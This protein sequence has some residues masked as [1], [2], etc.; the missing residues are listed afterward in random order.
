MSRRPGKNLDVTVRTELREDF[1]K[2]PEFDPEQTFVLQ[3]VD[4]LP[5]ACTRHGEQAV[6]QPEKDF[7]FRPRRTRRDPDR[8]RWVQRTATYE[9]G[10]LLR[11]IYRLSTFRWQDNSPP[12]TILE[13]AWPVCAK[14]QR[15]RRILQ[16]IGHVI[17]LAGV[18]LILIVLAATQTTSSDH[19]PVPLV[20]AVFPGWLPFGLLAAVLI[21][22]RSTTYVLFRPIT[23]LGS[24]QIVAHPDFAKAFESRGTVS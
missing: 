23:E 5:D 15:T 24:A 9:I 4:Q 7:E 17:V 11:G 16:Y 13:G 10:F 19:L 6:E 1:A 18:A 21:Y 3:L 8:T 20:L 14:C 2:D 22:R 12:S